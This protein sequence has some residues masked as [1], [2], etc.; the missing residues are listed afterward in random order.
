MP[1]SAMMC[2]IRSPSAEGEWLSFYNAL[3]SGATGMASW[4]L[5]AFWRM[6]TC[7]GRQSLACSARAS[8]SLG[9]Y[10][11]PKEPVD[12]FK[13]CSFDDVRPIERRVA[14]KCLPGLLQLQEH[15]FLHSPWLVS[16]CGAVLGTSPVIIANETLVQD[17]DAHD[18]R[19]D[20]VNAKETTA[21]T[22]WIQGDRIRV[23]SMCMRVMRAL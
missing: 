1:F 15:G 21:V 19:S 8:S 7:P 18:T 2:F 16:R 10:R 20:V 6:E 5:L 22:Q 23:Y 12:L 14:C 11:L 4:E 13:R 17:S 9:S 3:G